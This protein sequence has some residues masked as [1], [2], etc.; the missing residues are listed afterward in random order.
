MPA[1]KISTEQAPCPRHIRPVGNLASLFDFRMIYNA[2]SW[3][4]TA[5]PDERCQYWSK[6]AYSVV[7]DSDTCSSCN[8]LQHFILD[9]F[10]IA[11]EHQKF[12]RAREQ[13]KLVK[14]GKHKGAWELTLTYSPS[15]YQDD[16][17]AQAALRLA[18]DRLMRYYKFELYELRAVG[19]F[20]KDRRAH[21]HVYYVLTSGGKFTDKN[22]QRAYPHWNSKVKVGKG[23]QGGHHAP[24]VSDSDFRGYI[25]KDLHDSWFQL[26]YPNVSQEEV[27]V[28][29]LSEEASQSSQA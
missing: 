25:E 13:R 29:S 26:T 22:L 19:E 16:I 14:N 7:S 12:A 18:L 15:W 4:F 21:L 9:Q 20:T 17:E 5:S 1:T 27:V 2:M 10:A 3:A 11:M 28:P 8:R 24:V 6:N 23:N